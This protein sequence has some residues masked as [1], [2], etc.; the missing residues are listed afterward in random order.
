MPGYVEVDLPH[1]FG[2]D[3]YDSEHH[4]V[5]LVQLPL[6]VRPALTLTLPRKGAGSTTKSLYG[7]KEA[8]KHR[9]HM[10]AYTWGHTRVPYQKKLTGVRPHM[11]WVLE[12][13]ELQLTS[14]LCR[15]LT[16]GQ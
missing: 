16:G 7:G 9:I 12:E 4:E 1:I 14:F 15:R 6:D 3:G 11:Y 5:W 13:L 8:L 10:G 2:D